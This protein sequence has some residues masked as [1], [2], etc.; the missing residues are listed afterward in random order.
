MYLDVGTNCGLAHMTKILLVDNYEPF[1]KVTAELLGFKHT[2]VTAACPSEAMDRLRQSPDI[3]LL[4]TD[5]EMD[6][7]EAGL[8]LIREARALRP[9]LPVILNTAS[10]NAYSPGG[11]II[12]ENALE[13]CGGGIVL[14][15]GQGH[16][17]YERAIDSLLNLGFRSK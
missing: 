13:T 1:R 8:D 14:A 3:D 15:K 12:L 2:V 4:L 16:S 17:E 5:L 6:Q 11:R 9:G 7:K 10:A